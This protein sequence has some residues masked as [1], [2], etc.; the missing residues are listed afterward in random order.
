MR[1]SNLP[2]RAADR[3]L[4]ALRQDR[5]FPTRGAALRFAIREAAVQW[6]RAG[7]PFFAQLVKGLHDSPA[8]VRKHVTALRQL[9]EHEELASSLEQVAE[10]WEAETPAPRGHAENLRAFATIIPLPR[11]D[12]RRVLD[13]AHVLEPKIKRRAVK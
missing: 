11:P 13:R 4:D 1:N 8:S 12:K 5:G 10:Q 7:S 3:L 6:V 9:P 2:K